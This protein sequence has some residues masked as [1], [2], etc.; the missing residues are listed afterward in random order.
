MRDVLRDVDYEQLRLGAKGLSL[1]E[2]RSTG[3]AIRW[4]RKGC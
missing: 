4:L 3:L 1:E 2:I